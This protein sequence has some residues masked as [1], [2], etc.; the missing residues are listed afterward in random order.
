M[1]RAKRR[2]LAKRIN[3]PQK[4]EQLVEA[5]TRERT[6]DIINEYRQ[7]IV[8]YTEVMVVITAYVLNL[9]GYGKKRLPKIINRI[10]MNID[11]FRTGELTPEDYQIIRK[12]MEDMGVKF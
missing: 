11:S 7:K 3:T 9:E 4:L 12:E 8:D 5:T 10:L 2:E 1:N 6:A